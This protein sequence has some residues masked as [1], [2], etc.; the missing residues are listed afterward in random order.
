MSRRFSSKRQRVYLSIIRQMK[1][2]E[3]K[4]CLFDVLILYDLGVIQG[5][6]QKCQI[7]TV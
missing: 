6:G 5:Q 2:Y 4:K 3:E 7:F 1:A